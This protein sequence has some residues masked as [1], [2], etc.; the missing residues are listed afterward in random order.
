MRGIE[1][2][3]VEAVTVASDIGL[4]LTSFTFAVIVTLVPLMILVF[5]LGEEIPTFNWVVTRKFVL[6]TPATD[7]GEVSSTLTLYCPGANV[8]RGGVTAVH[9]WR[10][11]V[12]KGMAPT[13]PPV[14]F[15]VMVRVFVNTPV[16]GAGFVTVSCKV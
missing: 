16:Y 14:E 11:Y 3:G 13:P 2:L 8:S 10:L 6:A 15:A 12:G 7:L 4:P 1:P 5:G 9:G